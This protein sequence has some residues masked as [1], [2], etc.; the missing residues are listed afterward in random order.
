MRAPP[1]PITSSQCDPW[2]PHNRSERVPL[3]D[4]MRI[5]R[6]RSRTKRGTSTSYR[7]W[8]AL[9]DEDKVH[10]RKQ[11]LKK[12]SDAQPGDILVPHFLLNPQYLM[13]GIHAFGYHPSTS[14]EHTLKTVTRGYNARL[15]L[16]QDI[17]RPG[18][19]QN[20]GGMVCVPHA[21]CVTVKSLLSDPCL[22]P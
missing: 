21:P 3:K 8:C 22:R 1:P 4:I 12:N 10:W 13:K 17:N 11:F 16:V 18:S 7:D 2:A 9:S 20:A 14:S 19:C 5:W 15:V 6:Q